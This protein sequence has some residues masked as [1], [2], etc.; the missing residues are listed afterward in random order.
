MSLFNSSR[1]YAGG[2]HLAAARCEVTCW[3]TCVP[4]AIKVSSANTLLPSL[5]P[6][7]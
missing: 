7:V 1:F 2:C 4:A 3:L 6:L 5:A